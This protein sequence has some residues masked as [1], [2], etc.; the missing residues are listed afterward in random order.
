MTRVPLYTTRPLAGRAQIG[1]IAGR[2]SAPSPFEDRGFDQTDG[3][4]GCLSG[5][6][7]VGLPV[8]AG[9]REVLGPAEGEL[10]VAPQVAGDCG[11]AL[12]LGAGRFGQ[13]LALGEEHV[14]DI[15]DARRLDPAGPEQS[16]QRQLQGLLRL[17]DDV[18]PAFDLEE[19]VKRPEP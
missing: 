6:R 9:R 12:D 7:G 16:F 19:H 3:E 1:P 17:S 5:V 13:A 18:G 14:G 11:E 4:A 10:A 15:V 2:G 8:E